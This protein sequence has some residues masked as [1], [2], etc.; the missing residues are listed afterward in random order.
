MANLSKTLASGAEI[1]ISSGSFKEGHELFKA[2]L[3]EIGDMDF[4][5]EMD[6]RL[7]IRLISSDVIEKL[8]WPCMARGSY[9]K[10]KINP[11][12]FDKYEEARSDYL[13]IASEVLGLNLRPFL[14]SLSSKSLEK[15]VKPIVP[16]R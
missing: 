12:L 7:T 2:V 16:Q 14:Q 6:T 4:G 1:E 15:E 5:K 13:E 9:N 11:E 3:K 8:L 10:V